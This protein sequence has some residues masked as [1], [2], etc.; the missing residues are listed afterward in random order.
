MKKSLWILALLPFLGTGCKVNPPPA[1]DAPTE[2]APS[3]TPMHVEA[4]APSPSSALEDE[5]AELNAPAAAPADP[6]ADTLEAPAADA[7]VSVR[8]IPF[9][10]ADYPNAL[11]RGE[12]LGGFGFLDSAGRNQVVFIQDSRSDDDHIR[13]ATLYIQH[14]ATKDGV[15]RTVRNYTERIRDCDFDVLLEPQWGE[16]SVSD[17]NENG[18]G[19][20]SFA[21]TADCVSD[22]SPRAHKAFITEG[23]EKYV[24]R[25]LSFLIIPDEGA[26]DGG[27]YRADPMPGPLMK[28]AI[29]VWKHTARR[30]K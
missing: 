27:T 5:A 18:I 19:E 2:A 24:L 23:G 17:V 1:A 13:D 16:W 11:P 7:I 10:L 28:K 25:G 12:V 22:V 26:V 21:Y 29:E 3:D 4:P 6:P 30:G 15:T 14:I 8:S 9:D 20:A